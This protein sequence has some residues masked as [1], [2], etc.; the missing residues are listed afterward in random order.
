M[1]IG[2]QTL[3]PNHP[4]TLTLLRNYFRILIATDRQAEAAALAARFQAAQP[5]RGW[6]GIGL[7]S[8]DDPPG[9]LVTRVVKDSPAAQA[10][11][12]QDD[13]IVRFHGQQVHDQ[14]AFLQLVGSLAPETQVAV[15]LLRGG[16]P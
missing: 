6:L 15:E 1:D 4:D 7:A 16:Q 8:Q 13:L 9:I 3:G 14:Q 12:Q 5:Q 11:L 10:G 2:E